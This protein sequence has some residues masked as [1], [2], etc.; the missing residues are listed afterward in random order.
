VVVHLLV[1]RGDHR[2]VLD[3]RAAMHE[4]TAVFGRCECYGAGVV[5]LRIHKRVVEVAWCH[6]YLQVRGEAVVDLRLRVRWRFLKVARRC[7]RAI[8]SVLRLLVMLLLSL[9]VVKKVFRTRHPLL[10][11]NA[12]GWH[13]NR[14]EG[15]DLISEQNLVKNVALLLAE[16][17][18]S[19]KSF[20]DQVGL[21]GAITRQ[22]NR[23]GEIITSHLL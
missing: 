16:L 23:E 5:R 7:R 4:V 17:L 18:F 13:R 22:E 8:Q 10:E 9:L 21:G 20:L 14:W 1:L 12:A 6:L 11:L 19:A 2:F 15:L 3:H